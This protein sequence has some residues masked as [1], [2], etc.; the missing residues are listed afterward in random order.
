M[1]TKR[2]KKQ[3]ADEIL[4][5]ITSLAKWVHW[6]EVMSQIHSYLKCNDL[7]TVLRNCVPRKIDMDEMVNR[8]ERPKTLNIKDTF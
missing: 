1:K 6:D 3:V 7:M 2:K 4:G 8:D 5:N